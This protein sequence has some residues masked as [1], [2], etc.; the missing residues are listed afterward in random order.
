MWILLKSLLARWV[1]LK[2]VLKGLGSLD[3]CSRSRSSSRR[4][5]SPSW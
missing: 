2:L 1:V 5:G 4:S 3:G